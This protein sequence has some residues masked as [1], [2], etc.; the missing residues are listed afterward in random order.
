MEEP[1]FS[2]PTAGADGTTDLAGPDNSID[3]PTFSSSNLTS[4]C[5]LSTVLVITAISLWANYEA[6]KGFDIIILEAPGATLA[7][8][9]YN[10]MFVS[11]GGAARTILN[12]S[13][14]IERA[15][16]PEAVYFPRKPI[17]SVTL[18]VAG[19]NLSR[20]VIVTVA[21]D[22]SGDYVIHVS[23]NVIEERDADK[24]VVAA[25]YRGMARVWVWDGRGM[26]PAAVVDAVVGYIC[27]AAGFRGEVGVANLTAEGC[28][29]EAMG[30]VEFCEERRPG[31]VA[32]LNKAMEDRWE[33][34]V[35]DR[36]L[37]TSVRAMCA[38]FRAGLDWAAE[39]VGNSTGK[40]VELL[41][42]D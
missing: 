37:G 2:H 21:A 5:R 33:D 14:A 24:A 34:G 31:F 41:Q 28:E 4:V 8:R 1:L 22:G 12:A 7:V 27:G 38:G 30:F 11:N 35:L 15:L 18:R 9:H 17:R 25:L 42:V 3:E 19:Y 32:R 29:V 36:A 39:Q 20:A 10:L 23:P 6:S 13:A 16:Y 40:M 26:A